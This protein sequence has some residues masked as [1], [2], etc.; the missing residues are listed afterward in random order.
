[1]TRRRDAQDE[2]NAD[3]RV[4]FALTDENSYASTTGRRLQVIRQR[5]EDAGLSDTPTRRINAPTST[6]ELHALG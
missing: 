6:P 4:S 3:L 2:V 1:V 5:C